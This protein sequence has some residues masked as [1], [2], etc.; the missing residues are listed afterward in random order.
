[1]KEYRRKDNGNFAKNTEEYIAEYI[2]R[3]QSDIE[4]V[5]GYTGIDNPVRLRCK[6]CGAEFVRSMT[7]VRHKHVRCKVCVNREREE[8]KRQEEVIK[9]LRRAEREAERE[10]RRRIKAATPKAVSYGICKECGELFVISSDHIAY[11]SETC[12]KRSDNRRRDKRISKEAMVDKDI[13]LTKLFSRDKGVCHIC[14]CVCD[15]DDYEERD[16]AFIAG[17]NYPSIDHVRP[18]AKGGLH[19]W[20][21]VKLACRKCNTEK[22]DSMPPGGHI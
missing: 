12:R 3:T 17:W 13:T 2:E 15:W 22:S 7:T 14:G 20:D 1:M 4:Y 16:G 18:L 9:Q 10:E 21:N 8:R 11:C 6:K 19:S 5:G